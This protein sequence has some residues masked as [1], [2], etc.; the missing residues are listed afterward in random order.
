MDLYW[1]KELVLMLLLMEISY[2][3]ILVE[4]DIYLYGF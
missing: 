3:N 2:D 1:N 4:F